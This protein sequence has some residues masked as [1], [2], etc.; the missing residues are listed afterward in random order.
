MKIMERC[1]DI[2]SLDRTCLRRGNGGKASKLRSPK[3]CWTVSTFQAMGSG[4]GTCV[5]VVLYFSCGQ[6][7]DERMPVLHADDVKHLR[8]KRPLCCKSLVQ[9]TKLI[10]KNVFLP[11]TYCAVR[12]I[13]NCS[14][15]GRIS[16]ARS[17]LTQKLCLPVSLCTQALWH[18][19]PLRPKT[20]P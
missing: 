8:K 14:A 15:H 10:C 16:Y 2:S 12:K 20:L 18:S 4:W 3:L 5:R 6:D 13:M 11:E 1:Q 9:A 17:H 19:R 7:I